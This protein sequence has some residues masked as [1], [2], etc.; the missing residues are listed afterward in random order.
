MINIQQ[1]YK[2]GLSFAILGVILTSFQVVFSRYFLIEH[3]ISPVIS[4]L[5]ALLIG[6]YVQLAYL[7]SGYSLFFI[8]SLKN[9]YVWLYNIMQL[10]MSIAGI[11]ILFYITATESFL[12][13]R[14]T[15]VITL[16]MAYVFL[17]KSFKSKDLIGISCMLLGL[18]VIL[19]GF[20]KVTMITV[21]FL[22]LCAA[23]MNAARVIIAESYP[24]YGNTKNNSERIRCKS[25]ITLISSLL[26]LALIFVLGFLKTHTA[27]QIDLHI[28]ASAPDFNEFFNPYNFYYG[29]IIGFII[30]PLDQLSAFKSN[31]NLKREVLIIVELML[32]F[33][34]L[35][36]EHLFSLAGLLD[37]RGITN[38]DLI[39]GFVIIAG[40]MQLT[41]T[42][43][44]ESSAELT[45]K[46]KKYLKDARILILAGI[47]YTEDNKEK[48][49]NILNISEKM[50]YDILKDKAKL[51][52]ET[53]HEIRKNFVEKIALFDSLV[54]YHDQNNFKKSIH[55]LAGNEAVSLLTLKI[56][57][58]NIIKDDYSSE[59]V[60]EIVHEFAS[61]L[62]D[63]YPS[64]YVTK[65]K[66]S[67]FCLLFSNKNKY[68][69][70]QLT[71]EIK[72][73]IS[74]PLNLNLSDEKIEVTASID[75]TNY[76][77]DV[78]SIEDLIN[79][80]NEKIEK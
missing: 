7:G 64:A 35:L 73:L 68:Q 79:L 42:R 60:D 2:T 21:S 54:T 11:Y 69:A 31:L 24:I 39:A 43:A 78:K 23:T 72:K 74:Q 33:T 65:V 3:Q 52:K 71:K 1:N 16:L 66:D 10:I 41:F 44:Y 48:L 20:D 30:I 76:P 49:A 46:E 34:V 27:D 58:F 25:V 32:P 13:Q 17:N 61:I 67:E 45:K 29:L 36:T 63:N 18:G 9:A 4:I 51:T 53:M 19:S 22:V 59:T 50:I 70:R 12:L 80:T 47:E 57:D 15:I 37:I 5:L 40:A 8:R 14:I 56:D 55:N 38:L 77:E 6:S 62:N 28:I 26:F 75:I